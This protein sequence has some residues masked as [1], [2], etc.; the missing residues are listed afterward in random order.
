MWIWVF[1]YKNCFFRYHRNHKNRNDLFKN[2]YWFF[3][4]ST[5]ANHSPL[6]FL[7]A[8]ISRAFPI[9]SNPSV[10]FSLFLSG[11]CVQQNVA[12]I[13]VLFVSPQKIIANVLRL[14]TGVCLLGGGCYCY[15]QFS[16]KWKVIVSLK[17]FISVYCKKLLSE[18]PV[19]TSQNMHVCK[20][21]IF[22]IHNHMFIMQ[23]ISNALD[24][25][26]CTKFSFLLLCHVCSIQPNFM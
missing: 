21:E 9:P 13:Q 16:I 6:F 10:L 7:R 18:Y 3:P 2:H 8:I 24:E 19:M 23:H 15:F 26:L 14:W 1:R 25:A 12:E 5:A 22:L 4:I 17:L 20:P 11:S